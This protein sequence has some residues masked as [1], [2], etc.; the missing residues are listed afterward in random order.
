MKPAQLYREFE[1]LSERLGI[2][3][4]EGKG[5]FIGGRCQ[6]H[7]KHYV[8]LNRLR[9]LEQRLRVLARSFRELDLEPVYIMPALRAYIEEVTGTGPGPEEE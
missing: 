4:V 1:A 6:V 5:S 7:R 2:E 9:P 3:I 8:V